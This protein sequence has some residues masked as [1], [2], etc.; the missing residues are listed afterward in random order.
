MLRHHGIADSRPALLVVPPAVS[1]AQ[2]YPQLNFLTVPA[3][4]ASVGNDATGTD[5]P[6]LDHSGEGSRPHAQQ[7]GKSLGSDEPFGGRSRAS[8][9]FFR[10]GHRAAPGQISFA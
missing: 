4:R 5:L 9:P 3:D 1:A 2:S 6:L 10:L 7:L 8:L